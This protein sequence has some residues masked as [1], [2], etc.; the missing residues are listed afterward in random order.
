MRNKDEGPLQC[1]G[2]GCNFLGHVFFAPS[3]G[4]FTVPFQSEM[5][6][7]N[8]WGD[9][10]P[11]Y[12]PSNRDLRHYIFDLIWRSA[13]RQ[14]R[15]V[16]H[17]DSPAVTQ[18]TGKLESV[19]VTISINGTTRKALHYKRAILVWSQTGALKKLSC[20]LF[21]PKGSFLLENNVGLVMIE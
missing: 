3:P 11:Q 4:G 21:Q 15:L 17:R 9:G 12:L 5:V 19:D 16:L 10:W 1:Q 20:M 8:Q 7:C 6:I 14:G 2:H 13:E 18:W